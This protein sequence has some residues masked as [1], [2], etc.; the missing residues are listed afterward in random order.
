[1]IYLK[2]F[3][4]IPW[5]LWCGVCFFVMTGI[6]FFCIFFLL[7]IPSPRAYRLAHDLPTYTAKIIAYLWLVRVK[8]IGLNNFNHSQQY[9]FV[10]N[11]RSMLDAI[12]SAGF[13]PNPKKFIG[14]A[15][16]L[17]WPFIGYILKKLYIPV[18]RQDKASRQWSKEQ[19]LRKMKEGYSMVI[20]SEGTC[21]ATDKPLLD[22]KDG[23]YDTSILTQVSIVPFIIDKADVLWHRSIWLIQPGTLILSFLPPIDP[24]EETLENLKKEVYQKMEREYL[25]LLSTED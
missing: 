14:K 9:I 24:K 19:L 4:L 5:T 20:F 1:M 15:E 11:H 23:A 2:R 12:V 3:Y 7:F 16:L 13:I 10:G 21:N 25:R 17:K 18:K 8:S 6:C 22:F